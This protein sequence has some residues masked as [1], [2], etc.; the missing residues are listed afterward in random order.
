MRCKVEYAPIEWLLKLYWSTFVGKS[1]AIYTL[2]NG[3]T[4]PKQSQPKLKVN[5][6]E[7]FYYLDFVFLNLIVYM[8]NIYFEFFG[9]GQG[10]SQTTLM[11]HGVAFARGV[12]AVTTNG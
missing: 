11:G 12:N 2:S 10:G 6:E 8:L 7:S 9:F 1:I 3:S 5:G 4:N